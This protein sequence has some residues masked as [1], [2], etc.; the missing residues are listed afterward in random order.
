MSSIDNYL[1]TLRQA[2]CDNARQ[3]YYAMGWQRSRST[4]PVTSFVFDFFIY[5]SIYQYDWERSIAEA[6]MVAWEDE[7]TEPQQQNGLERFVRSQC[8]SNPQFLM[9]AFEPLIHMDELAGEWT[10]ITP[11]AGTRGIT[12]E[13]GRQFF[14]KLTQLRDRVRSRDDLKIN[15]SLFKLISSCRHFVYRIR[16][17]VF[18]GA[19]SIGETQGNRT[20]YEHIQSIPEIL[21]WM[22]ISSCRR[23]LASSDYGRFGP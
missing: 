6:D 13:E 8:A 3:V 12:T 20:K 4:M 5:N 9:R 15:K 10:E 14:R 19:K 21:T 17:A 2:H 23:L 7:P 18:H 16:N 1:D 11:I 22:L